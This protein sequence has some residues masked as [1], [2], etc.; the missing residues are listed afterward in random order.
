MNVSWYGRI[1]GKGENCEHEWWIA[2]ATHCL[3]HSNGYHIDRYCI[4]CWNTQC[5]LIPKE[6]EFIDGDDGTVTKRLK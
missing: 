4:K 2:D 1:I 6:T 5:G 3:G